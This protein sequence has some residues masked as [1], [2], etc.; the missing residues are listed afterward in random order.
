V[1]RGREE[2]ENSDLQSTSRVYKGCRWL[3]QAHDL[4]DDEVIYTPRR[5]LP[6]VS[7]CDFDQGGRFDGGMTSLVTGLRCWSAGLMR[8]E[9]LPRRCVVA[10]MCLAMNTNCAGNASCPGSA[11]RFAA[12]K[13]PAKV[14]NIPAHWPLWVQLVYRLLLVAAA[15][16]TRE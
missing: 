9:L 6:C 5:L 7:T 14:S 10:E 4:E 15:K 16:R 11:L 3:T 12:W 1:W 2:G 8:A 13:G